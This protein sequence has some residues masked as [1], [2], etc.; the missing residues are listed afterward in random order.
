MDT[1]SLQGVTGTATFDGHYLTLDKKGFGVGKTNK[2]VPLASITG[3]EIKPPSFG[4]R[5]FIRFALAG[6]VELRSRQGSKTTVAAGDENAI[7][8]KKGQAN[9]AEA[10]R[11]AIED[12]QQA[13][14]R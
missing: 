13:A 12:A 14:V 8:F 3:I 7:L 5:G 10:L 11:S 9:D 1:I 4:T 2:R 6:T